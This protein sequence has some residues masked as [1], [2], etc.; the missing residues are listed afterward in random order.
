MDKWR[1]CL[2]HSN[3]KP[4]EACSWRVGPFWGSNRHTICFRHSINGEGCN[5]KFNNLFLGVWCVIEFGHLSMHLHLTYSPYQLWGLGYWWSLDFVG[6]LN[7]TPWHNQY[8]LVM[9]E[10]F[11]KWFELVPLRD[12]SNEWATYA[13]LD[14]VLSRFGALAK[15][16]IDQGI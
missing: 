6:P 12:H 11:S 1:L 9:I 8:V 16:F 10:H 14:M 2:A 13:F 5:C 4:C 15:V 3:L 7:L